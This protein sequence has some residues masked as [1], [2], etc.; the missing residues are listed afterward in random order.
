M[1]LP[2]RSGQRL[3]AYGDI[4]NSESPERAERRTKC[5]CLTHIQ[6]PLHLRDALPIISRNKI[7]E[8]LLLVLAVSR[9]PKIE[10]ILEFLLLVLAVSRAPKTE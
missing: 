8:F 2:N 3:G 4:R 5:K 6:I 1:L 7:L 9:A 10:W